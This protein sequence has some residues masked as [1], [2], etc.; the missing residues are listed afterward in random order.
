MI[1]PNKESLE[2]CQITGEPM[3]IEN[4]VLLD[5]IAP[6]IA[7]MIKY[8]YPSIDSNGYI[9]RS[10]LNQYR[11]EY[12]RQI[13]EAQ[14]GAL[15]VIED[16]VL[17]SLKEHDLV[18]DNLNEDFD[19]KRKLGDKISDTISVFGG[20]WFFIIGFIVLLVAWII[21]NLVL[22]TPPDPYPFILL[23]LLL[24]CVAAFQ[25][26]IIM[27]SQRRQESRDRAR[28]VEDYKVNLKAELEVRHLHEKMDHLLENSMEQLFD[29]QQIQVE[30]LEEIASRQSDK[31]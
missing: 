15:S 30:L 9:S 25:A 18:A 22:T 14:K 6:R 23:N 28:A 8:K 27:M 10:F 1:H 11:L 16:E 20:S 17:L 13:L 26:P 3:N 2:I 12:I 24:S 21:T 5:V 7:R 31:K 4:L 19:T 29:I